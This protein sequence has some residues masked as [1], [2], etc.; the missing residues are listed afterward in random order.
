MHKSLPLAALVLL[1]LLAK[2]GFADHDLLKAHCAK[3][4]SG[5]KPKGDFQIRLLGDSPDSASINSWIN[6]LE[7]VKSVDNRDEAF[8]DVLWALI[9]SSELATV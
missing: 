6:S 8:E 5:D 1:S 2:P 7:Y 9:N 3:C 4:H